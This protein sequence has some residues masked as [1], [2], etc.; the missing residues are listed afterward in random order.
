MSLGRYDYEQRYRRR[1]LGRFIKL[2]LLAALVLG[3]GLFAY[4]MGIEQM[5]GRDAGLREEVSTLS[6]QKAELELLAGQMQHAAKSADARLQEAEARLARELPTGELARLSRLVAARLQ[7]GL[8]PERLAFVIE[9]A[10]APRHCQP[11]ENKRFVLATPLL[12]PS[13]RATTFGNGTITISGEGASSRNPQGQAESWFDPAQPV[14][15]RIV[16]QSGKETVVA[17]TLPLHQSLVVDN[18]EHRFTFAAGQRSF[19]DVTAD[20]CPFP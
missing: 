6:R 1:A 20:R 19:V 13:Q 12:R 7:S 11:P 16:T 4:Q 8:D 9:N 10:Q 5:K 2:S 18:T 14:R 3:T 17:G 15:I